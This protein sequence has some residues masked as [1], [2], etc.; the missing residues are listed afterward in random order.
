MLQNIFPKLKEAQ[1]EELNWLRVAR[2]NEYAA[3]E[4]EKLPNNSLEEGIFCPF[5]TH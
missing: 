5:K 3:M 4:D 1:R 2:V